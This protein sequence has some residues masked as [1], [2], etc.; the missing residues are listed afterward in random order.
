M[1]FYSIGVPNSNL[2]STSTPYPDETDA[3]PEFVNIRIGTLFNQIKLLF[4]TLSCVL[5]STR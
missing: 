2:Q 3:F 5:S 4:F 1:L